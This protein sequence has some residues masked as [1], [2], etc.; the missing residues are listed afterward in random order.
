MA[1]AAEEKSLTFFDFDSD[2]KG[3]QEP[4]SSALTIIAR[5]LTP[6]LRDAVA[7]DSSFAFRS[8][9]R[10]FSEFPGATALTTLTV[11]QRNAP[12]IMINIETL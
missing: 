11:V 7:M 9:W 5:E 1:F 12:R 6:S 4:S 10:P 8:G 3:L 2:H